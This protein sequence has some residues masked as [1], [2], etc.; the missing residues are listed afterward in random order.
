MSRWQLQGTGDF[1]ARYRAYENYLRSN[2]ENLNLSQSQVEQQLQRYKDGLKQKTNLELQSKEVGQEVA[3]NPSAWGVSNP[4]NVTAEL[5]KTQKQL[6]TLQKDLGKGATST[7]YYGT[8]EQLK[9]AAPLGKIESEFQKALEKSQ[10][11]KSTGGNSVDKLGKRKQK[12]IL[13]EIEKLGKLAKTDDEIAELQKRV[14]KFR[15]GNDQKLFSEAV[16]AQ[17][18]N[19]KAK[20]SEVVLPEIKPEE[21]KLKSQAGLVDDVLDDAAKLKPQAEAVDNVLDDAAKLKP[22]AEAVDDVLGDAA[23][24]KPEAEAASKESKGFMNAIKNAI[25]GKKGK[26][27]IAAGA[28]AA[29]GV[30]AYA[31]FGGKDDKKVEQ[32][33]SPNAEKVVPTKAEKTDSLEQSSK[34]IIGKPTKQDFLAAEEIVAPYPSE[35]EQ[36]TGSVGETTKSEAGTK[37]ETVNVNAHK[38]VATP[39]V[40]KGSEHKEVTTPETS[41][42]S[43]RKEEAS[44]AATQEANS[45]D[46]TAS[47]AEEKSTG[48]EYLVK[49]GDSFWKIAK[50]FLIEA[51]KGEQ[52]YEPSNTEIMKLAIKFLKDNNYKLD[53]NNYHPS[54]MLYPGDKLNLAA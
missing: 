40:S 33:E 6:E 25:K 53:E 46:K 1:Y 43:E 11:Y 37:K 2:A 12:Q 38:E 23:K 5:E 48:E 18:D 13:E 44:P 4:N 49:K 28:V 7:T 36:K 39:E 30:G 22:E 54:P 9:G 16:K 50:E 34:S 21:P 17:A 27:A 19:L 29:F 52:G 3:K 45:K 10:L 8:P 35:E 20:A 51:H 14:A 41:K 47:A 31:L 42:G 24:L 26:V 15:G 32:A